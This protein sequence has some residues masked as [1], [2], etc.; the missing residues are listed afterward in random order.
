MTGLLSAAL[1]GTRGRAARVLRR[2]GVAVVVTVLVNAG[3]FWSL[4][5]LHQISLVGRRKPPR[6]PV[7]VTRIERPKQRTSRKLRKRRRQRRPNQR[8][9]LPAL[10]LPSAVKIPGFG[11][12]P[13]DLEDPGAG[14]LHDRE[15]LDTGLLKSDQPLDEALVDTPPKPLFSVSPI[16]PPSAQRQGVEGAVT[17]R[18]LVGTDGRVERVVVLSATPKGVFERAA[19]AA[20]RRMRFS[21]ARMGSREVRVWV[22]K[23]LSFAL[24]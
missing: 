6:R 14:V 17:L 24:R 9:A 11:A 8:A 21:A 23:T 12:D 15:G 22:R 7:A 4:A 2:G 18:L 20:A 1:S 5:A 19:T 13:G 3:L 10:A 16:Y